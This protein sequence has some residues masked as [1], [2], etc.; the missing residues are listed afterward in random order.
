MTEAQKIA[1]L[2]LIRSQNVGPITY[3]KLLEQFGSAE[4]ALENLPELANKGGKR[5]YHAFAKDKAHAEIERAQA[6]GAKLLCLGDEDY[7]EYL[8]AIDDAPPCLYVR[9]HVSILHEPALAMGG[10]RNASANGCFM[11]KNFAKF[12]ALGG[13]AEDMQKFHIVSGLARGIDAAA[14]EGALEAAQ[15]QGGSTIA[16]MAGG[17]DVVYPPNHAKLYEEICALG[18]VVSEQPPGLEAQARHFPR[19]NR[20]IA[21]LGF[22]VLV[23]EAAPKS[24]SLITARLAADYGR[25]V[26]AVPG[27]PMDA[28]ARGGNSLIRQGAILVE[29]VEDIHVEWQ[30]SHHGLKD[31]FQGDG[32]DHNGAAMQ[33]VT[34]NHAINHVD[35]LAIQTQLLSALNS[36]PID[37]N[38]LLRQFEDILPYQA[39]AALLELEIS[40]KVQ[41]HPGNRVSLLLEHQEAAPDWL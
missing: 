37:Y 5:H 31:R 28:R 39:N 1:C 19:R 21:G 41:R 30:Q 33:A 25:D 6:I 12:L 32:F 7:P 9:G 3:R 40:G 29:R 16:V 23:M 17:V 27:S 34:P 38:I 35:N 13:K 10:A 36:T 14:H 8:A 20:I 4:K 2:R 22:G 15:Q 24:G 26:F 11:A 18:A